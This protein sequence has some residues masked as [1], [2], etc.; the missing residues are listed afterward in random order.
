MNF[1]NY[2]IHLVNINVSLNSTILSCDI[3]MLFACNLIRKHIFFT[4]KVGFI[5]LY[6]EKVSIFLMY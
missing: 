4:Y 3:S 5:C 2:T 6:L 1:L